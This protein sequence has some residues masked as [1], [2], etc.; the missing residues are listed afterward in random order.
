[1]E[2]DSFV[3]VLR[4]YECSLAQWRA[5]LPPDPAPHL[6]LYLA[7]FTDELLAVKVRRGPQKSNS[8]TLPLVPPNARLWLLAVPNLVMATS[9]EMPHSFAVVNMHCGSQTRIP[10][11]LPTRFTGALQNVHAANVVHYD[12]KCDNLLLEPLLPR[13]ASGDGAG[14]GSIWDLALGTSD[15]P[16]RVRLIRTYLCVRVWHSR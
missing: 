4:R 15:P 16:F 8:C 9:T 3:L 7:V 1:M 10:C 14:S 5:S 13:P 12:L 11:A 6:P 2:G